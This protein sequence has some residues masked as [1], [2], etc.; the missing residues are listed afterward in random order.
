MSPIAEAQAK[1]TEARNELGR[2]IVGQ[3]DVLD[4]LF[5]SIL[6]RGHALLVGVPGLAKTLI[7]HTLAKVLGGQFN[8]VQFTPDLMPSDITGVDLIQEYPE[9]GV[10]EF[11]FIKGPIFCNILLA[12]EINRTP[13]KTQS[14]LLQA[15]QEQ[16][17]SQ[18]DKTYN[19][20]QPFF[21]L[22]TQN[23]IEQEGTYPL[24]EAQLDRF[25]FSLYMN[26]PSF[27]NE[28]RIAMLEQTFDKDMKQC[29]TMDDL[30]ESQRMVEAIPVGE[31]VVKYA[32]RMNF[33]TRSN[34]DYSTDM[35]K[36]YISWGSGP[37]A[38]QF[39][40]AAAR[41]RAFMQGRPNVSVDDIAMVAPMVLQHR[42]VMNFQG[43]AEGV[44]V[45]QII[46]DLVTK[47]R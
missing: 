10:K 5:I 45:R 7:V 25:T 35:V 22:A 40:V 44:L 12:D 42:L 31:E 11:R 20:P 23:P 16:T 19:L 4:A 6:T 30:A 29:M 14:A 34:S 36:K 33:A 32:V 13:P 47:C 46:E 39:M 26:Y 24:P 27:D 28:V 3:E 21:V 41:A 9:T 37:R 8:R 1:L 17:V 18:G 38:S 15:M 43:E 2:L